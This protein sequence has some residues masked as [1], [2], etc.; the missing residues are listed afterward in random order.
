MDP[1]FR[2]APVT[3]PDAHELLAEYFTERTL[4]FDPTAGG[5]RTV[6][7][8]PATFEPPAGVFLVIEDDDGSPV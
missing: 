4:G 6:F 5:Y 2:A 7:P 8:V 3:D 1:V